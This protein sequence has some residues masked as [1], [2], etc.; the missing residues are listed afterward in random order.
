MDV[1]AE[2]LIFVVAKWDQGFLR[3]FKIK[4]DE[5]IELLSL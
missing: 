3:F 1:L 4:A 5:F 2:K